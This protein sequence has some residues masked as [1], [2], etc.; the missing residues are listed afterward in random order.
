MQITLSK[1]AG[2]C[3]GVDRAYEMVTKIAL[4]PVVKKPIYVLGS[5]VHNG[6]VVKSIERLGVKKIHVDKDLFKLLDGMKEKIGTMVITAHGM[7]P[8]IYEYA[9]KRNIALMDTTCPRVIKAQRLAKLF[10]D[11]GYQIV[12]VGEKDHKEVK[13]IGEWAQK[14]IVFVQK[15]ADFPKLKLDPR[16]KIA[17]ISQTTQN[18]EFVRRAW[19]FM[20]SKY[21][22][23]EIV[24]TICLATQSRQDEVRKKA[25]K[26]DVVVVIGSPDSANSNRLWEIA[27]EANARSYFLE[28]ASQVKKNWFKEAEK[29]WVTAGASTPK[30]VIS[31][32]MQKLKNF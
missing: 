28:R 24:D 26:N 5:L 4:D 11:K 15:D 18:Q 2:F 31:D 17:I 20:R 27:R 6:D 30:W 9:S 13:G 19:N 10:H 16:K 29:V 14:K 7:G 3:D 8:K 12:I 1:Y 21:P 32:V 23:V 22:K 25:R